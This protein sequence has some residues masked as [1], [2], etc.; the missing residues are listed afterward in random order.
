MK[1]EGK[2]AAAAELTS[3]VEAAREERDAL[4]LLKKKQ[5]RA[6]AEPPEETEEEKAARLAAWRE[7]FLRRLDEKVALIKAEKV[8]ELI[9]EIE[10]GTAE[11]LEL[12]LA[13]DAAYANSV[14]ELRTPVLTKAVL[15][16]DTFK[17]KVLVDAGADINKVDEEGKT[18]LI[19]AARTSLATAA[20]WLLDSGAEW[21]LKDNSE[22]T[23]LDWAISERA[24]IPEK[25]DDR[26]N[27]NRDSYTRIIEALAR[28]IDADGSETEVADMYGTYYQEINHPPASSEKIKAAELTSATQ[29]WEGATSS[30]EKDVEGMEEWKKREF[31]KKFRAAND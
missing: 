21:R 16:N 22:K 8:M 27:R 23:A 26:Q 1:T 31:G 11:N 30:F 12:V 17:M 20:Q 14:T 10:M 7:N 15:I 2:K 19:V 4:L 3:K 5:E 18:P 13:G 25:T 28:V 24:E 6:R 29:E 9:N